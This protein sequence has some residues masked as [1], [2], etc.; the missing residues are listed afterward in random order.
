MEPQTARHLV[1]Q[2]DGMRVAVRVVSPTR[3]TLSCNGKES[4]ID[5]YLADELVAQTPGEVDALDEHR[6]N[7]HRPRVMKL[8][9]AAVDQTVKVR[10]QVETCEPDL[11]IKPQPCL[12][13]IV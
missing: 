11:V 8:K 4:V 1:Q 10:K 3:W 12:D 7:T 6:L 5:Y 9:E 2:V 13:E